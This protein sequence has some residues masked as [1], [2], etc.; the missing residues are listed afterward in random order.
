MTTQTFI[1]PYYRL[2]ELPWSPTEDVERRF[3]V[4]V[5]NVLIFFLIIGLI[6][7]FLPLPERSQMPA[8]EISDRAV[9]LL[10]EKKLP[11][12]PPPKTEEPKPEEKPKPVEAKP[13]PEP[14]KDDARKKAEKAIKALDELAALRDNAV[15]DK[16]QQMKNLTAAVNEQTRSERSLITSKVGVGSGG[17]N[18]ANM[19]RGYGG[20][21][22][23]LSGR[24]TTQVTSTLGS[25]N[26]RPEVQRSGSGKS[27]R[28]QEEIAL[29]FDSN[30]GAIYSIYARALRE[31]PSLKGKVVFELSIAPSGEVL[32]CKLTSSELNDEEL[33]KKLVARVKLFKFPAHDVEAITVT[34]PIDFFPSG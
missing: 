5:R 13:K 31:N 19:S 14:P 17:I 24:D 26:G 21:T 10:I 1:A 25:T 8:S 16:A 27:A 33:E 7:P 30:K 28:S 3:R 11:P 32:S 9:K 20:G 22:G 2:Y 4:V 23:A 12:P 6:I 15:I 29:V 18:T 34:K